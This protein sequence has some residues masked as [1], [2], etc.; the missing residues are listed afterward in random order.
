ML[1][2]QHADQQG[3]EDSAARKFIDDSSGSY[4]SIAQ[5]KPKFS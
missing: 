5:G 2:S 3:V 1:F 4:G